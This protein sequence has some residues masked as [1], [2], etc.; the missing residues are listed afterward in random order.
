MISYLNGT[1]V[2]KKENFVVLDVAGV[3]YKVFASQRTLNEIAEEEKDCNLFCHLH[4]RED[5]MDLYGFLTFEEL[6]LFEIITSISGVGPKA[7]LQLAS[8]GSFKDFKKAIVSRD[9]KFFAGIH[10]IGMKKI[11]K[12]ILELTGKIERLDEVKYGSPEDEEVVGALV[13]LGFPRQRAREALSQ[14]PKEAKTTEQKVRAALKI[15]RG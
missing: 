14:I 11:Q 6:E 15:V 2:I 7:G 10:G 5:V 13:N 3:G 12:I 9:E 8:I 1:V 4:V